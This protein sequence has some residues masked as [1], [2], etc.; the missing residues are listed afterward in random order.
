MKRR[1]VL[2]P[3]LLAFLVGAE[4][5]LAWTWP[6]DGPVRQLFTYVGDP[7]GAGQHRG[8]DIDAVPGSP[9]VAPRSGVVTFA[10][11]VPGG[12]RT[13]T[14][15]TADGYSVTLLHLGALLVARGAGVEEGESVALA[16]S[17]EESRPPEAGIHLGVRLASQSSGYVD[18]LGLLPPRAGAVGEL[19][20]DASEPLPA[21]VQDA[22]GES[23]PEVVRSADPA[24]SGEPDLSREGQSP[25]LVSQGE[26]QVKTV[27]GHFGQSLPTP[28]APPSEPSAS[29]L[30]MVSAS[31]T[32]VQHSGRGASVESHD[33]VTAV[34]HDSGASERGAKTSAAV[35]RWEPGNEGDARLLRN[36]RRGAGKRLSITLEAPEAAGSALVPGMRLVQH[37]RVGPRRAPV[38][39]GESAEGAQTRSTWIAG[40]ILV[41][42]GLTGAL[43][44]IAVALARRPACRLGREARGN[45]AIPHP[46]ES[47][48]DRQ[49][50]PALVLRS[51]SEM[52]PGVRSVRPRLAARAARVCGPYRDRE[53]R[54]HAVSLRRVGTGSRRQRR[55]SMSEQRALR[56]ERASV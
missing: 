38:T 36:E 30:A 46:V 35:V 49:G 51:S 16:P 21:A 26:A 12:G 43:G 55:R 40:E 28:P 41:L 7:Y 4:P 17:A 42:L 53:A 10:G 29:S 31:P 50:R 25:V 14:I 22:T 3:V 19:P 8:I 54:R 13:L 32:P 52:L 24:D 37:E 44:G 20:S 18:P 1:T 27:E 2:L 48:H 23:E 15:S 39:P 11:S 56:R 6:A 5:A 33:L 47:C 45:P 9:I 34:E